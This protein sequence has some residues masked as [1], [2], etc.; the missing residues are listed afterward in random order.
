MKS[1]TRGK[2]TSGVEIQQVSPQG[3]WLLVRNTEYFLALRDFPWFRKATVEQLYNVR[4]LHG[5]HLHWPQL[6]IDLAVDSL[7]NLEKYPL[8]YIA[9]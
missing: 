7:K 6:D 2:S 3:I 1:F 4:L 5:N 8:K 9:A